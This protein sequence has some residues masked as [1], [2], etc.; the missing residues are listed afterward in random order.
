METRPF[1]S[2]G[3]IECKSNLDLVTDFNRNY[4]LSNDKLLPSPSLKSSF[5]ASKSLIL[6]RLTTD[7]TLLNKLSGEVGDI[8]MCVKGNSSEALVKSGKDY[9][10][11]FTLQS[12][13][14]PEFLLDDFSL[15]NNCHINYKTRCKSSNINHKTQQ[16]S[17]TEKISLPPKE[18][19]I[20][21]NYIYNFSV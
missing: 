9:K 11:D 15:K 21:N 12:S 3:F 14:I 4:R 7:N 18:N 16:D 5:Q 19:C 20:T 13:D 10:Q 2:I 8:F 6:N 1:N 17:S